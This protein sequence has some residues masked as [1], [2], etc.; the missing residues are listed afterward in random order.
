MSST[1][2]VMMIAITPSVNASS[3]CLPIALLVD[4]QQKN[5]QPRVAAEKHSGAQSRTF[6]DSWNE[7]VYLTIC[8]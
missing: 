2:M 1:M 7:K 4:S 8:L 3:R 5:G 6:R